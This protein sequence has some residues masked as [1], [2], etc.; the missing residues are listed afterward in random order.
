ML[1]LLHLSLSRPCALV[2]IPDQLPKLLLLFKQQQ[3]A[4]CEIVFLLTTGTMLL[5]L[6]ALAVTMATKAVNDIAQYGRKLGGGLYGNKARQKV[7]ADT[8]NALSDPEKRAKYHE[9]AKK[10]LARWAKESAGESKEKDSSSQE[11]TCDKTENTKKG[12]M[13]CQVIQ[14]DWGE[15]THKL[16]KQYGKTFAVLN[17]A[18]AYCA[19]GGYTEGMAAQEE[20]M[21]RRTDCHFSITKKEFDQKANRYTPA[22]TYLINGKNGK[23]ELDTHS[24]RVEL[25]THSPRVCLRGP[26]LPGDANAEN[27][28]WL[29]ASEIFPFY[30]LRSAAVDLRGICVQDYDKE[31]APDMRKRIKAQLDTLIEHKVR[32]VVLSAFGCGAF[33]NPAYNVAHLYREALMQKHKDFDVVAFAVYYPGY[34]PDNFTPFQQVF[35]D[36]PENR[37]FSRYEGK[38]AE[39]EPLLRRAVQG[40]D[41]TLGT[42]HQS[43]RISVR[44]VADLLEQRGKL[45]E[46]RALTQGEQK[47]D[48]L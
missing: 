21:F 18:N 45:V 27:Y 22:M 37:N 34:G 44:R 3:F 2:G 32:H 48:A 36:F 38:L 24:P 12:G 30:E 35:K 16:T 11:D 31:V 15:V 4:Q 20:N 33:A 13:I 25:D 29:D 8:L 6:A 5:L 7:L 47:V 26:E 23:V 1:S 40:F 10:N 28:K 46:A 39:A 19:G 17:M 42:E 14:G 41:K 9:V 43:T